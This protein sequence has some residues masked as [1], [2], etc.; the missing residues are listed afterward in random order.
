M[1][2]GFANAG[3]TLAGMVMGRKQANDIRQ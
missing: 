3:L 2:E 1:S